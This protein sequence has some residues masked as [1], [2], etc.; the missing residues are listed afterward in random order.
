MYSYHLNVVPYISVCSDACLIVHLLFD[1]I[2][3]H[4]TIQL[5]ITANLPLRFRCP[6][7]RSVSL[8]RSFC[9]I[10]VMQSKSDY[11]RETRSQKE[12]IVCDSEWKCGAINQFGEAY[13]SVPTT[14]RI[15][16]ERTNVH[17]AG[18]LCM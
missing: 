1:V 5:S 4:S 12:K 6:N 11:A 16:S 8:F 15:E 17:V 18:I 10:H 2:Y 14:Q 9:L 3:V 7:I 13:I